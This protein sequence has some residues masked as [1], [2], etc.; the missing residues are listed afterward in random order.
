MCLGVY[1]KHHYF[2]G[3]E[4]WPVKSLR[5]CRKYNLQPEPRCGGGVSGGEVWIKV[6]TVEK[7]L[8]THF[9]FFCISQ[10]Q[11]LTNCGK[12]KNRCF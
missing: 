9:C 5:V 8:G 11:L 2:G 6:E 4:G 3:L 1:A 7:V 10:N 12:P